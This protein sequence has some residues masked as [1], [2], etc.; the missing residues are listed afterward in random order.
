[1]RIL[2]SFA[3]LKHRQS[4]AAGGFDQ[5]SQDL[6]KR[7]PVSKPGTVQQAWLVHAAH[8]MRHSCPKFRSRL[9]RLAS[10]TDW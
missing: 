9:S 4:E 6:L 5:R 2:G 10:E 7:M 8:E 3:L 1:M